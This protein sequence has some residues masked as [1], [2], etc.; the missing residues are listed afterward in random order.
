MKSIL[1]FFRTTLAGGILFL[2][3]VV[4]LIILI[5]KAVEIAHKIVLPL[6]DLIQ[7]E[8]V[9][10]IEAPRLLAVVLL[11]LLCFLA[12]VLART[13]IAQKATNWVESAA[14]SNIPGY[15]FVKAVSL[16][17][18]AP[19]KQPEETIV[20]ARFDDA[21][22]IAFL[23]ERLENDLVAVFV[24]DSPHPQSGS[25]FIM[26]RDRIKRV[27]LPV[28]SVLKCLKGYGKGANAL[29]G[30]RLNQSTTTG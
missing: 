18:L 14:L 1:K 13:T 15:E 29:V 7:M 25:I 19:E 24:P 22:Q 12:G 23:V 10:G 27:D 11:V 16:S 3:P 6:A 4:V 30:S 21:W 28:T 9:I 8:P 17:L 2:L 5:G 26:T 20:L